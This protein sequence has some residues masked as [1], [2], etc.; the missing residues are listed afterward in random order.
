MSEAQKILEERAK[1]AKEEEAAKKV[2]EEEKEETVKKAKRKKQVEM[3]SSL[4]NLE[5][6]GDNYG[7]D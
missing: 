7:K 2:K 1:K 3:V 6:T 5:N 4:N